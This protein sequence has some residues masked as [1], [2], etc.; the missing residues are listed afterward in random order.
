MMAGQPL[1]R[2]T[3][4]M[5]GQVHADP[6]SGRRTRAAML[7]PVGHVHVDAVF[8]ATPNLTVWAGGLGRRS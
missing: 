8:G 1:T 6:D 7:C 3:P 5:A 2:R 4:M